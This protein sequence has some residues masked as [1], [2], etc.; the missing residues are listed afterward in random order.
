MPSI[1]GPLRYSI[2]M[3]STQIEAGKKFSISMQVTNP[4]DVPVTI[5]DVST[6]L[7]VELIDPTMNPSRQGFVSL[8]R[9]RLAPRAPATPETVS[10]SGPTPPDE[11]IQLQPGNSTVKTFTVRTKWAVFFPPASYNLYL[12]VDYEI[13]GSRNKDSVRYTLNIRSPLKAI[14][15]GAI[16]GSILGFVLK[17]IYNNP[18]WA[19]SHDSSGIIRWF[20]QLVGTL[21]AAAIAVIAFARK[22]D[23]QPILSIEDFWGGFF[24][25]FL[26]GFS[27]ES[28]IKQFVPAATSAVK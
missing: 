13:Y 1:R 23:T 21:L 6:Q 15:Y 12:W 5:H 4:Y 28:F 9:P 22:K 20:V 19:V 27:G 17:S 26:A 14:I 8:V 18:S 24:V 7:P 11:P 16:V 25:G 2:E 10:G 3:S